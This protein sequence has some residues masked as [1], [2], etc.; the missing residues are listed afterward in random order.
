MVDDVPRIS[1]L[2]F[3]CLRF[4]IWGVSLTARLCALFT[5]QSSPQAYRTASINW[6]PDKQAGRADGTARANALFQRVNEAKQV[7]CD[8]SK[9]MMYDYEQKYVKLVVVALACVRHTILGEPSAT[10]SGC[11]DL[12][13]ARVAGI[14]LNPAG[15][16]PT[17]TM[18]ILTTAQ[19]GVILA[20]SGHG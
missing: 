20:S 13:R 9:R 7:L 5:V 3:V 2:P 11:V 15:V 19:P 4:Y 16:T 1:I 10:L 17:L 14:R 6:H 8:S 12:R 18:K